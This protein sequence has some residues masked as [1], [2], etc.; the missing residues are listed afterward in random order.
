MAGGRRIIPDEKTST[1]RA[2]NRSEFDDVLNLALRLEVAPM[3]LMTCF[4]AALAFSPAEKP[5][6]WLLGL[7]G[8]IGGRRLGR[9]A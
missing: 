4:G 9:V 8:R 6:P 7:R 1:M 3:P 5:F 2:A